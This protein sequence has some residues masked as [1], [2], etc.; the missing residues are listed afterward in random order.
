MEGMKARAIALFLALAG[1]VLGA[2]IV[3]VYDRRPVSSVGQRC[4]FCTDCQRSGLAIED[5]FTVT[6][7]ERHEGVCAACAERHWDYF[8]V[9]ATGFSGWMRSLRES[10]YSWR[11]FEEEFERQARAG[12]PRAFCCGCGADF[13]PLIDGNKFGR[14]KVCGRPLCN[15]CGSDNGGPC[16][17]CLRANGD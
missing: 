7:A 12:S 5:G 8:G 4:W 6:C 16:P 1:A 2:Y 14:C 17:G 13:G 15:D 10:R 11:L 3:G 9:G